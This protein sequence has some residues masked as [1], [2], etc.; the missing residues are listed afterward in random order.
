MAAK[1]TPTSQATEEAPE[2]AATTSAAPDVAQAQL[3][4]EGDPM[5]SNPVQAAFM[6]TLQEFMQKLS[7][8]DNRIGLVNGF[9][10]TEKQRGTIKD[11]ESNFQAR[12]VAFTQLVI[13]D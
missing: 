10:Y 12:Y 8:R 11:Y 6:I 9:Y 7:A 2:V 5:A 3:I 1:N 4:P 13:E